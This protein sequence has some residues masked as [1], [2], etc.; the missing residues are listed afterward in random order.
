[1][2]E[3]DLVSATILAFIVSAAATPVG[4]S[5]AVFLVPVQLSLLG[6]PS[7]LVTPTNLLY[8]VIAIPGALLKFARAGSLWNPLT[9]MLC[10]GTAPGVVIGAVLRTQVL[11]SPEAFHLVIAAVLA[12]LG[13]W[14]LLSK[15]QLT[16]SRRE[17]TSATWV[18]A[19]AFLVGV[20]GGIYGIGG[21]SIL[22]PILVGLG[23]RVAS[24]A[25]AALASTFITSLIGIGAFALIGL[26]SDQSLWPDWSTGIALGLGGI[27]GSFVGATV[28]PRVPETALRRL[29]GTVAVVLAVFYTIE[30]GILF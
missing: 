24:V 27:V 21:G 23:Y 22:A 2:S 1:M 18:L 9:R 13:I 7:L 20:V 28:Q 29:L 4:V 8:N 12:P 14:M 30:S 5:G 10:L 25:P 11:E 15:P 26:T 16:Q 6:T 3:L 19:L 17:H